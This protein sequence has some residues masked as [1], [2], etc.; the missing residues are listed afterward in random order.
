MFLSPTSKHIWDN[1]SF[2]SMRIHEIH[3]QCGEII[4]YMRTLTC[5]DIVIDYLL[6]ALTSMR[7]DTNNK[8]TTQE[9]IVNWLD[10]LQQYEECTPMTPHFPEIMKKLMLQNALDNIKTFKEVKNTKQHEVT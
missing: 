10:L 9:L 8:R 3:S 4:G 5:K 1:I 7:L 2:N 6:T